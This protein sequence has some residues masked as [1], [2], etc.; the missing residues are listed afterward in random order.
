MRSYRIDELLPE[1]VA[2]ASKR[3]EQTGKPGPMQGIIWFELPF[4]L[5]T[6]LQHEHQEECG[7]FLLS[8]E[9]GS[10]WISLEL[11]VRARQT[12]RCDCIGFATPEQ[13]A[14][15]MDLVDAALQGL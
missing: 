8:V 4:S 11:L 2:A 10:T 14:Y 3:M 9:T 13:R 15:A 12:L 6:P 7:P 1:Q 5:L